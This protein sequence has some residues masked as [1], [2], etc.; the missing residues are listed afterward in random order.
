MSQQRDH[1]SPSSSALDLPVEDE[2]FGAALLDALA[3][4]VEPP[5]PPRLA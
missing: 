1:D 4:D 5:G 2:R 3:S